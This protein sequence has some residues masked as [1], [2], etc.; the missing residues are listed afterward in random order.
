MP[1]LYGERAH[2]IHP[3]GRRDKNQGI[4]PNGCV[5]SP[6]RRMA[7]QVWDQAE[8]RTFAGPGEGAASGGGERLV[9]GLMA[10]GHSD[11][12]VAPA[13]TR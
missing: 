2:V 9:S 13:A 11:R 8:P 10:P 3:L 4:S 12:Q 6:T 7:C 1:G 5:S